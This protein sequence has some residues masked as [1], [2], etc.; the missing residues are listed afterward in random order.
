M[1]KG[2]LI[3]VIILSILAGG[4]YLAYQQYIQPDPQMQQQLVKEFGSDF[5]NPE[6]TVN[7]VNEEQAF[8]SPAP[9]TNE[10]LEKI[11]QELD[12][13][14]TV[15]SSEQ[16]TS[17]QKEIINEYLPRFSNLEQVSRS[18]LNNLYS[19]GLQ[20]YQ[21]QSKAGNV[22]KSALA[23]KYLTAAKMLESNV[24][25]SFNSNLEE[26]RQELESRG[27]STDIIQKI[28][29]EYENAKAAQRSEMLKRALDQIKH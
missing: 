24:D 28:K 1:K 26:M 19:A 12:N 4:A 9:L 17:Q 8:T 23:R 7:N 20:E 2:I 16:K 15:Q 13:T 10:V 25:A 18:R 11:D 27:L 3:T 29:Q 14:T 5:F 6:V 22:N 21:Q